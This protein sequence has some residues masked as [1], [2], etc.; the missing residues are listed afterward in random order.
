M[1]K[2]VLIY[3]RDTWQCILRK[4][5]WKGRLGHWDSFDHRPCQFEP[6]IWTISV[7]ARGQ[8]APFTSVYILACMVCFQKKTPLKILPHARPGAVLVLLTRTKRLFLSRQELTAFSDT[9]FGEVC[10]LRVALGGVEGKSYWLMV[11]GGRTTI[12]DDGLKSVVQ[13]TQRPAAIWRYRVDP[14]TACAPTPNPYPSL[15]SS[16]LGVPYS[17]PSN[18]N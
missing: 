11:K 12:S 3:C 7:R 15:I 6:L 13:A 16:L 14:Y 1:Y 18:E 2:Q 9:V 8:I 5:V 17:A 4:A 10:N